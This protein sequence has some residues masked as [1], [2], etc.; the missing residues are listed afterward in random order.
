MCRFLIEHDHD[1]VLINSS[2]ETTI[3]GSLRA[4]PLRRFK[5]ITARFSN[6]DSMDLRQYGL[7][8]PFAGS[9]PSSE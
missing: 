3:S 7:V 5:Q 6:C 1:L 8:R 4:P 9:Y 2:P